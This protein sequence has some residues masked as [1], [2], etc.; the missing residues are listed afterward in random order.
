MASVDLATS[1]ARTRPRKQFSEAS[2]KHVFT[3]PRS[4]GA[5]AVFG[6]RCWW[7]Y[8]PQDVGDQAKLAEN[9]KANFDSIKDL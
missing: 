3:Q 8:W 2:A 5:N 1:I 6:L 4:D 9:K 7:L